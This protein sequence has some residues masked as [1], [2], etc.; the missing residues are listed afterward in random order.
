M[1]RVK[2]FEDFTEDENIRYFEENTDLDEENR[3][4]FHHDYTDTIVNSSPFTSYYNKKFESWE[5]LH[6]N[7]DCTKSNE[8]YN[9]KLFSLIQKQMYLCP[10]WT[11]NII[12]YLFKLL[13]LVKLILF[14]Y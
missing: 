6:C 11:G 2:T 10:L 1:N 9:P 5:L 3:I 14:Y 4:Y 13:L 12:H 8:F 7:N